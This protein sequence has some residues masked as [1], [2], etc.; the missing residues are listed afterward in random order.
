KVFLAIWPLGK[1]KVTVISVKEVTGEKSIPSG[2]LYSSATGLLLAAS[3]DWT[4]TPKIHTKHKNNTVDALH[5]SDF[6][7]NVII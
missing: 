1:D 6:L 7:N 5:N 3:M 4:D 2:L